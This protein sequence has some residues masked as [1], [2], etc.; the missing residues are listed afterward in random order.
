M[1]LSK[2]VLQQVVAFDGSKSQSFTFSVPSGGDQVTQNRLTITNQSTGVQVYQQTQTTFLYSHTLPANTLTNGTYYNAYI[3][4]YNSDGTISTNSNIIQFYCYTQPTLVFSNMPTGNIITNVAF[5]FETTYTQ[6]ENELLNSYEYVLYD[7][8]QVEIANSGVLYVGTSTPPPTTLSY[9]FNGLND[10]TA[11]YI[12]VVGN[13]IN[14]TVVQTPLTEFT[15]QYTSPTIFTELNLSQNCDEGYVTIQSNLSNL[16][17]TSFPSP[18]VYI[19]GDTE[20]DLTQIHSWVNWRQG[21]DIIN[22]ITI[23]IWGRSFT[24]NTTIFYFT[25]TNKDK[26]SINYNVDSTNMW[27]SATIIP[28]GWQYG[29]YIESEHIVKATQTEQVFCWLRRINSIYYLQIENKGA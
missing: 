7:A 8:Q 1:A 12:Q 16:A 25:N 26:I 20:V 27:W 5:S 6:I 22:N 28:N 2:P 9:V 17:G 21:I 23:E 4:T 10:G 15:T 24:P 19:T 29:Y 14:G 18:P 13:T 11:Y 3:N